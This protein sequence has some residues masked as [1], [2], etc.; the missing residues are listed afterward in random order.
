[1]QHD[2]VPNEALR[3][4]PTMQI[5]FSFCFELAKME[6]LKQLRAKIKAQM[7]REDVE[8]IL[9]FI[10]YEVT[11]DHK[12]KIRDEEKTPSASIRHDG[13][14]KDFGGDFCGDAVAFLHE[15]HGQ[16]LSDATHFVADCLGV[17]NG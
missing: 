1:M 11:R 16:T 13:F 10:G 5:I 12:F 6:N 3:Q 17:H 4:L 15:V 8:Q 2:K 9:S 7:D 14:I